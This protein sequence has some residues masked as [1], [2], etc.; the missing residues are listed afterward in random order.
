MGP[1]AHGTYS[2]DFVQFNFLEIGPSRDG[3]CEMIFLVLLALSLRQCN[4]PNMADAKAGLLKKFILL[5]QREKVLKDAD[6]H[7]E[8]VGK[9]QLVHQN[10]V[11]GAKEAKEESRAVGRAAKNLA[12]GLDTHGLDSIFNNLRRPCISNFFQKHRK[13]ERYG[14]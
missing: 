11:S 7:E 12:I 6:Y 2:N 4:A 14:E 5:Y 10:S 8:C 1:S 13:A 3:V 9:F